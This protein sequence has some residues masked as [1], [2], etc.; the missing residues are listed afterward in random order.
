MT[1]LTLLFETLMTK[2]IP[3]TIKC[4]CF[5]FIIYPPNVT[6]CHHFVPCWAT[7][8]GSLL[9]MVS[10]GWS[11][12]LHGG[13]RL[14]M[15]LDYKTGKEP[16]GSEKSIPKYPFNKHSAALFS[17]ISIPGPTGSGKTYTLDAASSTNT[18]SSPR[19][20]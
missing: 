5:A 17:L 12:L 6:K 11:A 19:Y 1:L 10:P 16:M 9:G 15:T 4:V 7:I 13:I 3:H 14:Y 20:P 8:L 2:L 18:A